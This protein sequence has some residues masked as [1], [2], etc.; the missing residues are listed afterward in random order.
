MSKPKLVIDLRRI[1]SNIYIVIA[2]ARQMVP[3]AQLDSFI[4][5]I[6]DAQ[7]PGAG[8][9]DE[10]VLAMVN[11]YVDLQDSSGLYPLYPVKGDG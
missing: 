4:I 1:D 3:S 2:Q 7:R 6:L 8:K 5:A 9:T 11:Q 10:E